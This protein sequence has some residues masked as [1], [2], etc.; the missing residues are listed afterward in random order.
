[1]TRARSIVGGALLAALATWMVCGVLSTAAAHEHGGPPY[2]PHGRPPYPPNGG[3]PGLPNGEPC[4]GQ[5]LTLK[6]NGQPGSPILPYGPVTIQGVLHCGT[7]PIRNA[8]VA[9]AAVGYV[10]GAPLI[11]PSI[12]TGLDGSFTYTVPPGPNR[13]LSFS[14]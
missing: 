3:S 2:P 8:Q 14:Y 6:I 1:M 13:V 11:A 4:A 12:T 5:E 10:A 9:V 7:V